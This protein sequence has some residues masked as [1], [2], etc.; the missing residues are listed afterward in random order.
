MNGS[1]KKDSESGMSHRPVQ[2]ATSSSTRRMIIP[3]QLL[4]VRINLQL[5]SYPRYLEEK[6]EMEQMRIKSFLIQ[7]WLTTVMRTTIG[8]MGFLQIRPDLTQMWK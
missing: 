8:K 1:L 2:T 6:C 5:Q 7:R 3:L 4:S